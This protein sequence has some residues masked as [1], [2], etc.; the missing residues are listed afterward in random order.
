MPDKNKIS[1]VRRIG[2][3]RSAPTIWS[4]KMSANETTDPG[5]HMLDWAVAAEKN[6]ELDKS[7]GDGKEIT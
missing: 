1:I 4:Q 7:P 2:K 3:L 5:K 6:A